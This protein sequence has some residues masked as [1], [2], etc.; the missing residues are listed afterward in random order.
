MIFQIHRPCVFQCTGAFS[1]WRLCQA[2]PRPD[3]SLLFFLCV[4]EILR[5][6]VII[7]ISKNSTPLNTRVPMILITHQAKFQAVLSSTNVMPHEV[8]CLK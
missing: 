8:F 6:L 1:F 5:P 4:R 3:L 2:R 7:G